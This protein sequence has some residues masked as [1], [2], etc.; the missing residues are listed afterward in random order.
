MSKK[1]KKYPAPI[2]PLVLFFPLLVQ[3]VLRVRGSRAAGFV[4]LPLS[5]AHLAYIESVG[6]VTLVDL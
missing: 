3:S 6:R 5:G 2:L 1:N 4:S